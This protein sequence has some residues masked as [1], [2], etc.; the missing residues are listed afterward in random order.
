MVGLATNECIFDHDPD[1]P[2]CFNDWCS[3]LLREAFFK[4]LSII[5][6]IV[7]CGGG[8][9]ILTTAGYV[10]NSEI[11]IDG[12][13]YK[14]LEAKFHWHKHWEWALAFY[15]F[16]CWWLFEMS[17]ARYQFTVSYAC[18]SWYFAVQKQSKAKSSR[19]STMPGPKQI[20]VRV[21]GVDN[22]SPYRAGLRVSGRNNADVV[23]AAAGIRGPGNKDV[24]AMKP[25]DVWFEMPPEYHKSMDSGACCTGNNKAL[26]VHLGSIAKGS[27]IVCLT[28][29]FRM[30]ATLIRALTGGKSE[31]RKMDEPTTLAAAAKSLLM[32]VCGLL[33]A[34][35]GGVSKN[36][37]CGVILGSIDFMPAAEEAKKLLEDAGGSVA[38]L[39]GTCGLYEVIGVICITA[40]ST[41]FS[42]LLLSYIPVFTDPK[43]ETWYVRD[44][45]SMTALCAIISGLIAYAYMSLFNIAIDTILFTF[46]WCRK[47]KVKNMNKTKL[48]NMDDA[49]CPKA[50]QDMFKAELQ[51]EMDTMGV[52]ADVRARHHVVQAHQFH[53]AMHSMGTQVMASMRGS[54]RSEK[55]PLM[56]THP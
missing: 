31:T 27:I 38:Y 26:T 48:V 29:P 54:Q 43:N 52:L 42:F 12:T 55:Q 32:L 22:A 3:Q 56:T 16:M 25:T 18:C 33:E 17:I 13:L 1:S 41:F 15:C 6:Q 4:A 5:L 35:F 53:H 28:R 11:S 50:L 23:V 40:L 2:S 10:D 20:Q 37:Y 9:V 39:H 36:A 19:F 47:L 34:S 30:L 51:G 7:F 46:S 49:V 8:L 24:L 14:G 44:T 45:E 21:G